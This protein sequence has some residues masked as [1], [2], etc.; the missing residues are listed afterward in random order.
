MAKPKTKLTN[1]RPRE[2]GLVDAGAVQED[3]YVTKKQ[4][5]GEVGKKTDDKKVLKKMAVAIHKINFFKSQ[6][7][8][9]E[10]C[11]EKMASEGIEGA[12][13]FELKETDYEYNFI[14]N[15]ATL[16]EG[17]SLGQYN[18]VGL[19]QGVDSLVG[20][21]KSMMGVETEE[22][23]AKAGKKLSA[24]KLSKL[25]KI[26]ESVSEL[27]S[28]LDDVSED[29]EGTPV[30]K[31]DDNNTTKEN[32]VKTQKNQDVEP[33]KVES[34]DAKP[35]AEV[36]E[37]AAAEAPA[38]AAAE[39]KEESAEAPAEESAVEKRLKAIEDKQEKEL[40]VAKKA[41]IDLK[42]ENV[43]LEKRLQDL[44]DAPADPQGETP[45]ETEEVVEKSQKSFWSGCL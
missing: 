17:T 12:E 32:S 18:Y 14:I 4:E 31:S 25:K 42:E 21:L 30:V 13:S 37:E 36:K 2:V 45:D 33:E 20:V 34:A 8:T 3:F 23:V 9:K 7:K 39:V 27:I 29:T 22:D 40:K 41:N 16:F 24:A 10:E 11:I 19:N 35:A 1:I 43:K 44:E 38:E 15:D 5:G 6:Y 26:Q 28:E